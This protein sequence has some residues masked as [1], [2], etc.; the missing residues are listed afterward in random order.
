M[1]IFQNLHY[2][3]LHLSTVDGIIHLRT[4]YNSQAQSHG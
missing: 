1:V 4:L 3:Y 2:W